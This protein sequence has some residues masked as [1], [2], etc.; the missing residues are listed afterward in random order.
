MLLRNVSNIRVPIKRYQGN[1]QSTPGG[2]SKPYLGASS[3]GKVAASLHSHVK[4]GRVEGDSLTPMV[5]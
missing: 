4:S 3:Y 5:R 1:L 2:P